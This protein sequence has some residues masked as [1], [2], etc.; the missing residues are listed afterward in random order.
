MVE[1]FDDAYPT[2]DATYVGLTALPID[3]EPW[4]V[5]DALGVDPTEH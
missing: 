1:D 4:T 5:S 2:C 3:Q